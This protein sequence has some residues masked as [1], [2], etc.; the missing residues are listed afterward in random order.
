MELEIGLLH[1]VLDY[2]AVDVAK[3]NLDDSYIAVGA[4][5]ISQM[6]QVAVE[7]VKDGMIMGFIQS[8]LSVSVV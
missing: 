1:F 2:T 8:Q 6:A 5:V 3:E 4:V 7:G